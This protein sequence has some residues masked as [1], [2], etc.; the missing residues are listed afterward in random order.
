MKGTLAWW[1]LTI[2]HEEETKAFSL[3]CMRGHKKMLVIYKPGRELSLELSTYAL[4]SETSSLQRSKYLLF[5][6]VLLVFCYCRQTQLTQ[7]S[8]V[9]PFLTMDCCDWEAWRRWCW[10]PLLSSS[11]ETEKNMD[12]CGHFHPSYLD[13]AHP[14]FTHNLWA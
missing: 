3:S 14:T 7:E 13:M 12:W 2:I 6:H 8:K 11:W 9:Y 1:D 5:R 4:W 10:W